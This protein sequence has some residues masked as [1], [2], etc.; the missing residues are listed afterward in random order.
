LW[1]LSAQATVLHSSDQSHTYT[2]ASDACTIIINLFV[3]VQL[4]HWVTDLTGIVQY[5]LLRTVLWK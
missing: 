5:F 4:V 2:H 1:S 3:I